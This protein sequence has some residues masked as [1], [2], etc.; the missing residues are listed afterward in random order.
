MRCR[1]ATALD[2]AAI[3][4]TRSDGSPSTATQILADT[5]T[6]SVV[7]VH[8]GELVVESYAGHARADRTHLLMSV[9]KSV[10]G[11]VAGVLVGR[12]L[13]DPND[14]VTQHVPELEGSGYA[15][16]T[17]RDLLDMRSGI[18]FREAYGDPDA[19]LAELE[20]W[21]AEPAVVGEPTRGLY[22]F[23]ATLPADRPHG[24]TFNY[25]SCETDAL[26]W[27]LE[28]AAG[29]RMADLISH[30]A[31]AADRGRVR[32]RAADRRAGDGHPRRRPVCDRA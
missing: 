8:D 25:R 12:G 10:V 27:V 30:D 1:P 4:V 14:L 19:E 26:G 9:T 28:R 11:C 17:V 32:R 29:M 22:A 20:R 21:I 23:L 13:I 7:V 31:V 15:G 5:W 6:D 24:Q 16:A 18:A 3:D 2:L